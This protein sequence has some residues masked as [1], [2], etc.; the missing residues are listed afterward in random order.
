MLPSKE[1]REGDKK[2]IRAEET[3]QWAQCLL[4]KH[5]DQIFVPQNS[6]LGVHTQVVLEHTGQPVQL[7]SVIGLTRVSV[8]KKKK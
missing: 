7:N 8:S 5:K 4:N 3:A 6:G 1:Q 2:G